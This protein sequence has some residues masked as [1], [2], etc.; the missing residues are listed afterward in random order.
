MQA[1]LDHYRLLDLSRDATPEQIRRAYHR[2]VRQHHPDV[3]SAT[4]ATER[5][6]ALQQAYEI[7]SNPSLRSDYDA[8]LPPTADQLAGI[9]FELSYSRLVLPRLPE[10]QLVYVYLELTAPSDSKTRP[11]PPLN[12]CLILDRSTSMRGERMDTVK[13]TAV[14]L[15]RQLGP[16]DIFSIV[17]FSDRAEVLATAGSPPERSRIE[18]QIQVIQPSGG[19]EI[20]HGLEAG[21]FEVRSHLSKEYINHMILLTDGRTYGDEPACLQIASQAAELGIGISGLGIGDEYNDLFMDRLAAMTGGSSVYISQPGDIRH[22]LK[23]RLSGL[24][25]VFAEGVTLQL[26]LPAGVELRYAF[27]LSPDTNRLETDPLILLGAVP[28][29]SSL[30][31]V[32]EFLLPA[33][34]QD[35]PAYIIAEARLSFSLPALGRQ[36]LSM[37]LNILRPVS[38]SGSS[39]PPPTRL[40]QAISHLTL[41]RLQERAQERLADGQV[42]AASRLLQNLATHLFSGGK[43][44]LARSVLAEV[45]N[46]RQDRELS[47][48]GKKGIKYATRALLLPAGFTDLPPASLGRGGD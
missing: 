40:L 36:H 9:S 14:E 34:S 46:L 16:R 33:I 15:L 43:P 6:L 41:Y 45:D 2:A 48:A 11:S 17:T 44:E 13:S 37:P 12:V 31:V 21:F 20:L 27:R 32:L 19:T 38:G 25:Q 35:S 23:Q 8:G 29:Q 39:Q 4:G 1:S 26:E 5:F 28:K 18:S 47:E 3:S 24:G 42:E 10:P 30:A 7:L 22:F